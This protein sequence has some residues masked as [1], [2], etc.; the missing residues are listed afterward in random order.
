MFR[1]IAKRD[2]QQLLVLGEKFAGQGCE[3]A[4]FLCLDRVF[5]VPP[6]LQAAALPEIVKTLQTFYV[7][8]RMLRKLCI[9]NNPCDD[10]SVRRIFAI[11]PSTEDLVLLPK[12]SIL[13]SQHNCRLT[14]SACDTDQGLLV[15]R[16][17]LDRLLKYF[18]KDRLLKRVKEEDTMLHTLRPLHPCLSYTV[19]RNCNRVDCPWTHIDVQHYDAVDYNIRVR[20][21][22][23]QI[24]IYQTIYAVENPYKYVQ[25]QR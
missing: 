20:V 4:A 16:W 5:S 17:E 14:P 9:V 25:T 6:K 13:A 15:P 22:I 12:G 23:L 19:F 18:L 10:P 2:S 1:S 8:A 24:L 3:P 21:H 7:Y 11:S